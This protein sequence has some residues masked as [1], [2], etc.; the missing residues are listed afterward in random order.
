[1]NPAVITCPILKGWT[2][3]ALQS[4]MSRVGQVHFGRREE[5]RGTTTGGRREAVQ[6]VTVPRP[7]SFSAVAVNGGLQLSGRTESFLLTFIW[8]QVL[9]ISTKWIHK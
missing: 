6:A 4:I 9:H 5:V 1:M 7:T 8:V 2:W 3:C